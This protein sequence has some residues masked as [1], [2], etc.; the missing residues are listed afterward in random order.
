MGAEI[1]ALSSALHYW[2]F[3]KLFPSFL[4]PNPFPNTLIIKDK[5]ILK[6]CAKDNITDYY[7]FFIITLSI[8]ISVLFSYT[9]NPY[10]KHTEFFEREVYSHEMLKTFVK[11]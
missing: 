9:K 7:I 5:R 6:V 11:V 1:T 4:H 10:P 3:P 2:N 8:N